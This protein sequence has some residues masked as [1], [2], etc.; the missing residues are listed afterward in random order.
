MY[1]SSK[2]D[3]A[4]KVAI[5]N[6]FSKVLNPLSNI[7]RWSNKDCSENKSL[8][9][10][11]ELGKQGLNIVI[12]YFLANVAK[13]KGL[14]I[15]MERFPWIVLNRMFEKTIN[16]N[17]RDDH[18]TE[19]CATN[20]ELKQGYKDYIKSQILQNA[21]EFSEKMQIDETWKETIIFKL[22]TKIATLIECRELKI[23][24]AEA[25][26]L[27]TI[28]RLSEKAEIPFFGQDTEEYNFFREVSMLR[29]S[30]RWLVQFKAKECSVLEHMGEVAIIAFL[31]GLEEYNDETIATHLFWCGAFH[32]LPERWTGDM[33]SN[34][35]D[36]V[37]GLRT[38]T[39]AF[40]RNVMEKNVY[41]KLLKYPIKKIM[42]E[43]EANKEYKKLLKS[44]DYASATFECYRNIKAGSKD[45][46]FFDV[47]TKEL[48]KKQNYSKNFA[49]LIEKIYKSVP[50]EGY[51]E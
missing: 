35:K 49:W 8:R 38:A 42:M 28:G 24:N 39:E 16:G 15:K 19:I 36:A 41:K 40:E 34:T 17:I 10:Y 7:T 5:Y 11:T 23:E 3:E 51:V 21:E 20:E 32:D 14:E 46:Y 47:I 31:M 18:I 13:E 50:H 4:T 25:E 30:V 6:I 9:L 44:A 37:E 26:V 12:T 2:N 29:S 45:K 48:N 1:T 43:E 27:K 22:A 33:A